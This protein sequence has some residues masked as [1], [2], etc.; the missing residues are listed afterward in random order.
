MLLVGSQSTL[1]SLD[2]P[3]RV[4]AVRCD[5]SLLLLSKAGG[6]DDLTAV[7]CDLTKAGGEDD[8]SNDDTDSD[9]DNDD[10]DE[11]DE[12]DDDDSNDHDYLAL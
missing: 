12:D 6:E 5:L 9:D 3:S 10:D 4:I 7:K 1:Q 11:D 2:L 8:N